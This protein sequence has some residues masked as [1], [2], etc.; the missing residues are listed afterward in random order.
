[1]RSP[2]NALVAAIALGIVSYGSELLAGN[3]RK[4]AAEAGA[5]PAPAAPAAAAPAPAAPAAP[6]A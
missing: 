6:A 5:A 1:M 3:P 4:E 2:A